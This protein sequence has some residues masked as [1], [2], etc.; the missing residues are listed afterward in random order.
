[1]KSSYALSL[2]KIFTLVTR[3]I[4]EL[5]FGSNTIREYRSLVLACLGL[6]SLGATLLYQI[7]GIP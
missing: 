3:S 4:L 2:N 7:L 1:M 5:A 6:W